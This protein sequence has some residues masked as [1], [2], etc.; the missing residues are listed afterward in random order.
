MALIAGNMFAQDTHCN[1]VMS[2]D[3][4]AT[5]KRAM[6]CLMECLLVCQ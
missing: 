3:S 1:D 6:K 5:F 4:I 2:R